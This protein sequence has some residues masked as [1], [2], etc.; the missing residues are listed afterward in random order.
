MNSLLHKVIL[1]ALSSKGSSSLEEDV[2]DNEY[3]V[4][5]TPLT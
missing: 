2:E 3:F 4:S 5:E 1:A